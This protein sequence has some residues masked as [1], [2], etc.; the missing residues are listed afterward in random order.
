MEKNDPEKMSNRAFIQFAN[1]TKIIPSLISSADVNRVY[2][3]VQS[4]KKVGGDEDP[5]LVFH[6]FFESLVKIACL[7]KFKLGG[8]TG[9]E[10]EIKQREGDFKAL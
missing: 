6:D 9:T 5:L 1:G 8:L 3:T 7:S 2:K 10:E 4:G